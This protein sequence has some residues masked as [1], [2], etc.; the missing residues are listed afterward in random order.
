[1]T[2]IAFVAASAVAC[3]GGGGSSS[4]PTAPTPTTTSVTVTLTSPIRM[5]QTAQAT[6]TEALSSGQNQ[7]VTTGWQS[8]APNVASVTGSGLVTGVAN[9]RAT[10]FVVAGGRMGQQVVRVVPDYQGNWN[11]G[12]R[13]TS[14]TESGFFADF[15]FCDEF[16]VG[17]TYGSTLNITQSGE[18]ITATPDYGAG[19]VLTTAAAPINESG[20]TSFNSSGRITESGVTLTVDATFALNSARVGELTGTITEVWRLPNVNGEGRLA[21]NIV[22]ATR[23]GAPGARTASSERFF[24]RE[25][26]D[27]FAA[28]R[29]RRR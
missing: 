5:G 23:S 9:G 19:L 22:L 29:G 21:H 12:Q 17:E 10:I 14:C 15:D 4:A 27:L 24:G 11:I 18:Q 16:P 1:L 25:F 3:G 20:G 26:A 6:G 2:S 13:V 28:V 8:D 7:A